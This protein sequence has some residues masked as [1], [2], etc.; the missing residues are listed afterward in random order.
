MLIEHLFELCNCN[1]VIEV[2]I[3]S[4]PLDSCISVA[5]GSKSLIYGVD[6]LH[7]ALLSDK[8]V[9]LLKGN[10]VSFC[11]GKGLPLLSHF[12][13]RVYCDIQ[14]M[15]YLLHNCYGNIVQVGEQFKQKYHLQVTIVVIVHSEVIR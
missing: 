2:D 8:G 3:L 7:P 9:C 5:I 13:V 10:I 4:K 1:R 15:I 6:V 14:I 12:W 11:N